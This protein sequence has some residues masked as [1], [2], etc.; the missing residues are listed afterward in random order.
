MQY[1]IDGLFILTLAT[2]ILCQRYQSW[3]IALI[4]SLFYT[5]CGICGHNYFHRRDN[6]RMQYFNLL[7][8][9]FRDWRVS[10]VLAHHLYPN[11]LLDM[12]MS[13]LYPFLVWVPSKD[14]KNW[15]QRYASFVYSPFLYS[16][17][18]PLKFTKK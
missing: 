9:N 18:Y 7:F 3:T 16:L 5:W 2:A 1:Y 11:T 15:I 6:Y 17:L 8:M 4:C 12:E 14:E 10:H 13:F